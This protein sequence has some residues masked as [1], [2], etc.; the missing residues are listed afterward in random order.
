LACFHRASSIFPR[1]S[2]LEARLEYRE[3][4]EAEIRRAD[5]ICVVYS[6]V[7]PATFSR[8]QS[9]WLPFI[10]QLGVNVS[11]KIARVLALSSGGFFAVHFHSFRRGGGGGCFKMSFGLFLSSDPEHAGI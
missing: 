11:G 9:F 1:I 5:V 4:L 3:Q 10:R 2:H 6:I 8:I 7:D